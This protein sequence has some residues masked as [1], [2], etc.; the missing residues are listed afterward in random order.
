[1]SIYSFTDLDKNEKITNLAPTWKEPLVRS[2]DHPKK[3]TKIL[4]VDDS[5]SVRLALQDGLEKLGYQVL[6]AENG[7]KAIE[8][9]KDTLPDVILSDVYMPE[10]DGLELCAT[11]HGNPLFSHIPFVVM[12]TENDAGNMRQMM[13]HASIGEL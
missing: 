7:K 6:T 5:I 12:S 11:L 10:M 2:I 8:I 4:V 3:E 13:T 9:L 1:M